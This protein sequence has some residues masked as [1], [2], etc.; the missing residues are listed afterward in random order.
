MKASLAI[1]YRSLGD[2]SHWLYLAIVL[3]LVAIA[4]GFGDVHKG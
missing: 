3:M 1:D 2:K 4:L